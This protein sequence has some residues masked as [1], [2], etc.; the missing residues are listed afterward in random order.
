MIVEVLR[1]RD[2]WP[3]TNVLPEDLMSLY[4]R[5]VPYKIDPIARLGL[6]RIVRLSHSLLPLKS[7]RNS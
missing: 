4:T 3:E 6:R 7:P 2:R 1:W 5:F